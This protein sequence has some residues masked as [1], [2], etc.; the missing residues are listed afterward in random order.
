MLGISGNNVIVKLILLL[1]K[2]FLLLYLHSSILCE[3]ELNL[4]ITAENVHIHKICCW[5]NT[6]INKTVVIVAFY[7]ILMCKK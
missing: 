1:L 5:L 6:V 2:C 4:C 7:W 3:C